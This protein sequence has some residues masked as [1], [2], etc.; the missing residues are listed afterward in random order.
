MKKLTLA[1]FAILMMAVGVQAQHVFNK[2]DMGI[3]AG[4]GVGGIGGLYPSIEASVEFGTIPTGDIGLVSF[5]GVVG[6]KYSRQTYDYWYY[7]E[8]LHYNQFIIGGRGTWHL[9]TFDSDKYDVYGGVGVGLRLHADYN[10]DSWDDQEGWTPTK[11]SKASIYEEIFVGGRMM[12]NP[13]FGLF[14][15][16][17]YS[18][19]S[20]VRFGLTFLM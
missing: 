19:I 6:W 1:L 20:N 15:E 17:G 7:N 2:G 14:A 3:N 9:H 10:Y 8:T 5:G 18:R 11:D 16:V 13:G 4:I 12:L